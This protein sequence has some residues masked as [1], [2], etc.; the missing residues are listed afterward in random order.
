[1]GEEVNPF[2]NKLTQDAPADLQAAIKTQNDLRKWCR[3]KTTEELRTSLGYIRQGADVE[4]EVL[5]EEIDRRQ[6]R[7]TQS[8]LE[9]LKKPH[10]SLPWV[11]WVAVA[12][13]IVAVLSWL[14]P[15]H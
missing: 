5:N 2:F 10:W 7:E 11:F 4:R 13:F 15:R 1:M 8:R 3:G 9:S 12:T 6:H 14:F